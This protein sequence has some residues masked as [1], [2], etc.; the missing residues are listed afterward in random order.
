MLCARCHAVL[1]DAARFCSSCGSPAGSDALTIGA[2]QA[3][4]SSPGSTRRTPAAT[5]K[6]PSSGWLTSSDSIS[7]GRFAPGALLDGRYRII[8]LLGRG[9]MGEVYRADDLRLGQP[10]AVK[11][12]PETLRHDPV[13]LAQFH[14]EV[15]TARQVSHPNVCRVYDIG[16]AD[17]LMYLS[18][19]Y[20]DGEDLA[21]S[22]RR[23]GRFPE[24]KAADIARQLCAGLAA[25]HQRGV[26]H[27]D[28]KPANV[29]LDGAGRVRVMDFGLA[30]IGQ[31]EDVRAGTPAN[32]APEQL[33]GREVTARSDIFALGLVIYELFTGRRA[34]TA[35]TVADLVS[36]HEKMSIPPPSSVVSAL[37]PAIERAILRCLAA[38]P[39]RRPGSALAVS[40]ALPG[41]DPLAAALEAG[42][43]PSP[44]MVAAAGQGAGLNARVAW[45]VFLA[46]LAGI[47]G[48]FGMALRT[49][50]LDR[51]RPEYT[52]EVLAQKARDAVRQ[53]APPSRPARP[54]DEAV[55]FR[56]NDDLVA[57]VRE[58]DKPAP[59]WSSVYTQ[60]PSPLE[61]WY[62]QSDGPLTAVMFHN[63]LLT[64]GLVFPDD[65][66]PIGSGMSHIE[67]D[68]QGRL[69][70]FETIPPQRLD[71]PMPVAPVDWAPVFTLAGLDLAQLQS[72][73]PLW[74]WLATSDTRKA[75]TGTWPESGRPLRV[76][77][78]ALGGR[79]VAFMV[80]GP[81][82]KPW[83]MS[84]ASDGRD[85]AIVT[86][87][88]ALLF[89]IL[90]GAAFLARKN[91]RSGRGDLQAAT[92]L[93]VC[94]AAVLMAVW[95]CRVHLAASLGMLAM[96]LVAV[97]TS[98][99][100][101]VL[102]WTIY[103][104][105]E[106]YVRKHWP[107]VLVSSTNVLAGRVADP[108]VGRDVL[109]GT[110]LGVVW[111][112]LVQIVDRWSGAGELAGHPGSVELLMGMRGTAGVIL[113]GVPYAIRNVFFNFFLL[114]TLRVVLRRQ[115]LAA[116]AFAGLFAILGALGDDGKPWVN[117]VVALAYFGSGAVVVLRWGLLAYAV[118]VFVSELLLKV[119][120]TLDSSAWYFGS[121]LTVVAVAI[122]L[123]S[124]ALYTVVPRSAPS[125]SPA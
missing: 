11:L 60:R 52:T 102:L 50:P 116:A 75:W 28:L 81:W 107:Q 110:A 14:N 77:A 106:P 43:T 38:A 36:Q 85:T 68:H 84:E 70:Y 88:F 121:M 64:P 99:F 39:D 95:F 124:W 17:G 114:F 98:A 44:E 49:S 21:S 80:V 109:L 27:R 5:G 41:G 58:N 86:V 6:P 105:L 46:V 92:R 115:W 103:V 7:H 69:T 57:H 123:A 45:P 16:E 93:G 113:Q 65:P 1:P 119:P 62:R 78:A 55:G 96:F 54:R 35:T 117:A 51:I 122:A 3:T 2:S 91:L 13:R 87:L 118:G 56:W 83:R 40:A 59:D 61:L 82:R 26:V 67:L 37:D 15:R 97:C 79:P 32:M 63:D 23:I 94:M 74:T 20:V 125:R 73:D 89:G 8:G 19:E 30:A 101:G 9:G 66:P 111:V 100:Y 33:L 12:L 112:L 10:V 18:M 4:G 104:A 31:V 47:A 90:G 120:A 72:A 25:A 22:L 108:V 29:M 34:F 42:E 71:A 76:E 24:D 48:V 53:L